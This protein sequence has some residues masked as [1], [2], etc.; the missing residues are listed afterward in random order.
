[1]Q[2]EIE[3]MMQKFVKTDL[4]KRFAVSNIASVVLS[5][6][7]GEILSM[8][9][10]RDFFDNEVNGRVNIITS[11]RQ[12]G[13]TFKPIAYAKA[14]EKGLTPRTIVYDVPTQFTAFCKKDRFESTKGGCYSPVNYTGTFTGPVSLRDAL[15]QSINVPAV[16]TLYIADV[17]AVIQQARKMGVTSLTQGQNYYG[18]SLVLG[19]AEVTPLEMAQVYSVFANEGILVP[20][21]WKHGEQKPE[22]RVLERRVSQD[23]TDMLSDDDARAPVFGRGSAMHITN[24]PVAVKTG[25]TNNARDIWIIGYSPDII[26]LVWAGNSDNTPLEDDATGYYLAPLM[27]DVI[28]NSIKTIRRAGNILYPKHHPTRPRTRNT[29]RHNR[30]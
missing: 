18:L 17:A 20:Y 5:A 29:L 13:S 21:V 6:K 22:K 26:V 2:E 9:G 12:P 14:I 23:I 27:R 3:E 30:H 11:L 24:P 10:S 1:M 25:T 4:E 15:A 16:K 7:T 28:K 8:V 19:G